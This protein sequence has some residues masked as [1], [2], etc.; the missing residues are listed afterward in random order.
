MNEAT[1][2]CLGDIGH[3]PTTDLS[4]HHFP[5]DPVS[6]EGTQDACVRGKV[7]VWRQ[8]SGLERHHGRNKAVTALGW[9]QLVFQGRVE[10]GVAVLIWGLGT[11]SVALQTVADGN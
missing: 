10:H 8:T 5:V 6:L 4:L 7:E 2:G 9:E 1:F 3:G 11:M